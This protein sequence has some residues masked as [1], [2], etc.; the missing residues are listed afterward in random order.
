MRR[1]G[2]NLEMVRT[3]DLLLGQPAGSAAGMAAALAAARES[4]QRVPPLA[5]VLDRLQNEMVKPLLGASDHLANKAG[6]RA[7]AALARLYLDM[8]RWAEAAAIVR[9]GWITRHAVPAALGERRDAKPGIDEGL[10]R[11]AEDRWTREEGDVARSVAEVRNDI[12]HAGFKRQP[13]PADT[14]QRQVRNL[15]ERFA[16]LP[17]AA[18]RPK[19]AG[20]TPVFVNLSNHPSRYWGEAQKEAAL[21]F[22]PEIHDW[23][24]PPVP[25]EAEAAAIADLAKRTEAALVDALPGATH[26]MVQG[27]FTLAHALVRRLQQRGLV[28]LV[29]TT[30]RQ[31]LEDRGAIKTTRFE[32]VRFREYG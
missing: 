12:E 21:R 27:E 17:P 31:V 10:R 8:G 5:D 24:F 14:L 2:R 23:P 18:A 6:H 11:N 3:G 7:L 32:F 29:A 22:A 25:P 1:F 19:E 4:A 20:V 9:E 26:V 28:C 13:L 15:V 16:V 30:R